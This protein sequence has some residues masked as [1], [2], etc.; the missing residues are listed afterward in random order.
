MNDTSARLLLAP[1][2]RYQAEG[3]WFVLG[4]L[5]L[6][7][8]PTH[9]PLT[10][11]I[12]PKGLRSTMIGVAMRNLTAALL[13]GTKLLNVQRYYLPSVFKALRGKPNIL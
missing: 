2:K 8:S 5:L 3:G 7:A 11:V 10:R 4:S 1:N 9:H 12:V 6:L 13:G